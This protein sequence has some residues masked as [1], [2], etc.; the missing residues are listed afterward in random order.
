MSQRRLLF[1]LW[2]IG[3]LLLAACAPATT[4]PA[5]TAPTQAPASTQATRPTPTPE[6]TELSGPSFTNP[7]Y[8]NDFP[9]PHI[10]LVEDT[11]YAYATTNG[12]SIN[13][14]VIRSKDLLNWEDLGDALPALPKWSML[15][16]GYT[17][18]PGVIQ[19]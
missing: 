16:A 1:R 15:N 10:I 12:S 5:I 19:I 2:G 9:D 17:W 18:A 6:A 7:V 14:R 8:K 3:L 11:Y 13:I 4:P